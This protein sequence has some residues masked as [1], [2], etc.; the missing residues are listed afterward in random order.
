[1][2]EEEEEDEKEKEKEEQEEEEGRERKR[3]KWTVPAEPVKPVMKVSL[4]S[5]GAMYSL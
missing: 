2:E 5:C 3:Q 4:A 1:M